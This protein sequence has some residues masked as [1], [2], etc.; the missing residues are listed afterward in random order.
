MILEVQL[1]ARHA[2]GAPHLFG[3]HF[4]LRFDGVA[5]SVT[6]ARRELHT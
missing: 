1:S 2:H 3:G 4:R 6:A 5:R